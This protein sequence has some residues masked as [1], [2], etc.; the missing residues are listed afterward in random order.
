MLTICMHPDS[1]V[2]RATAATTPVTRGVTAGGRRALFVSDAAHRMDAAAR[3]ALS[4]M[5]TAIR[6]DDARGLRRVLKVAP[7]NT[8]A[9]RR[10]LAD[11]A[12]ARG[13]YF[14]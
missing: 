13:G 5:T 9:L 12:V 8:V 4:A 3:D 10:R 6:E 7:T 1:A 14:L 2:L 11:D